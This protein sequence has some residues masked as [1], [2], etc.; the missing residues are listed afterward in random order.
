MTDVL[1]AAE[2]Y[3]G[4]GWSTIPIP[5]RQKSP[6]LKGWTK[7]RLT[8][9]D[10]PKHFNGK[11]SNIGVL[12][13][14]PSGG[15]IDVDLDCIEAVRA[16]PYLLPPTGAVFGRPSRPS[17]HWLYRWASPPTGKA[18]L[19]L[20]AGGSLV[21][22]RATSGKHQTVFPPSTHPSGEVVGWERDGEPAEI[23]FDRLTRCVNV[24]GAAA[25]IARAW[26]DGGRHDAALALAGALLG[27]G[28]STEQV[29]RV[30]EAVAAGAGD[31]EGGDRKRAVADSARSIEKGDGVTGW[32]RLGELVG[33]ETVERARKWMGIKAGR[34][35]AAERSARELGDGACP[36]RSTATG[37]VYD[38]PTQNGRVPVPVTNFEATIIADT[39]EDDGATQRRHF[40]VRAKVGERVTTARLPAGRFDSMGWVSEVLGGDALVFAGQGR[41][42]RAAEAIK[43]LSQPIPRRDLFAH[44]GW[45]QLDGVG[46]AYL[47]AGGAVGSRGA[48]PDV[49]TAL[50]GEL[51]RFVL[52]DPPEG[53]AL[54]MAVQAVLWLI[55]L[56]PQRIMFPLVAAVFRSVLGGADFTVH[57]SGTSGVFKSELAGLAQ[58][59]FGPEL[60]ARHLP[61]SWSSTDGA[62]EALLFRAKDAICVVD[63]FAPIGTLS[64]VAALQRKA[65]RI[66]RAQGN[67]SGRQRLNA[68]LSARATMHPRGLTISTGEDIPGGQ[69]CRARQL[70]LEIA[71]GD[72]DPAQLTKCQRH[73]S[74]GRYAETVAAF[75]RWIAGSRDEIVRRFKHRSL[76]L[77]GESGGAHRRTPT[78]TAE[79]RAA[80]ELFLDFVVEATEEEALKRD[81]ADELAERCAQALGQ[82]TERQAHA[83]EATDPVERFLGL[84]SDAIAGRRAYLEAVDGA[85]PAQ[86]GRWGWRVLSADAWTSDAGR[87]VGYVDPE[88]DDVFLLFDVA[89]RA[90]SDAR[91]D[92]LSLGVSSQTLQRRLLEAG[93]L[94]TTDPGRTT[95]R[96]NVGG[97]Q[98]R[99]IHL[100][101]SLLAPEP[102]R[103]AGQ[104]DEPAR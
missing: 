12:L 81:E 13:G 68:D 66:I 26:P 48:V 1:S 77:R 99:V 41:R 38:Q 30:V 78:M 56:A 47:H 51:E 55:E 102:D 17:S 8:V 59:H 49:E 50:T 97:A 79:L 2:L 65:D 92:G 63:D 86:P 83:Q 22:L 94:K 18:Y 73:A 27:S 58:Q 35:S 34:L 100:P 5:H 9:D 10:L 45:R 40:D 7:L 76:A 62:L 44:T 43:L 74:D 52:P 75:V 70:I 60:D 46:W 20:E 71:A 67:R 24:L 14:E 29:E 87:M 104:G 85:R 54:A 6:R 19:K 42:D 11:P 32:T 3:A 98:R 23:A 36:Y 28:W 103:R 53:E 95:V 33:D 39:L 96:K 69:S 93:K 64:E 61:G 25:L 88:T 31:D 37:I 80:F 84:L 4:R 72:V 89:C 57:L 101:A 15:L 16:A 90:A 82:A 21:E 91:G